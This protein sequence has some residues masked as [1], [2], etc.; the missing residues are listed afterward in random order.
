[1]STSCYVPDK[2]SHKSK[3][4]DAGSV[5]SLPGPL[6]PGETTG[7]GVSPKKRLFLLLRVA[8]GGDKELLRNP[9]VPDTCLESGERRGYEDR[10][11]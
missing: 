9:D 4:E 3:S 8:T 1:M 11:P 2:V 6:S 7:E 5:T 10:S